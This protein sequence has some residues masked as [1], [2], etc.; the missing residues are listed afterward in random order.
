VQEKRCLDDI[1][2]TGA[3][4]IPSRIGKQM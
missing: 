1:T 2:V 4:S 3:S